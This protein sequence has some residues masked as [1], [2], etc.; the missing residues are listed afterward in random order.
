VPIEHKDV[1][2]AE[3]HFDPNNPR[4]P[5]G[6]GAD[7]KKIFRYLVDN[8]GVEDL[9]RA[10]SSSGMI[11]SDPIIVRPAE[12][13][14]TGYYVIE[15]NRRLAALRLLSGEQIGND[16][17]PPKVP[18]V[19]AAIR[20]TFDPIAVEEGW[21]TEALAS[22]LGYKHVTSAKEWSP[23]AK[24]RF[25]KHHAAGDYSEKSLR[26]FAKQLGTTYPTLKRWLI[27]NLTLDE[28][29]RRGIFE[30]QHATSSRYFGRFYTL[31]GGSEV[32]KFLGLTS[33]ITVDP[34]PA[35]KIKNLED[36]VGWSVGTKVG[37]AVLSSRD[38]TKLEAVLASPRALKYF[39]TTRDLSAALF[40][41]E[42]NTSE[43]AT[44]LRS[45]S[46]TIEECLVKLNDVK[47]D[48]AVIEAFDD[49][50]RAYDKAKLNM[51]R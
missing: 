40:Y 22:Y 49:L 17:P 4:L 14:L 11:P 10:I 24:A 16:L 37:K 30:A 46:Y 26:Q 43:I 51:G 7:Q 6:V 42:Y 38:Q 18:D 13:P 23:E 25:V 2:L 50:T 45:A 1:R 3:L 31:L 48:P 44:Q 15:G 21:E 28:A 47:D 27:A 39:R 36:F 35:D 33:E 12:P 32:Q 29:E 8:I 19:T 9:L 34:V 5:L 41:T 20:A